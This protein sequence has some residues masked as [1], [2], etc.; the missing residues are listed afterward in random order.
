MQRTDYDRTHT[1][2]ESRRTT[3]LTE[4]DST[5]QD[6]NRVVINKQLKKLLFS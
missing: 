3:G 2:S 6:V 1:L 4:E 5:Q